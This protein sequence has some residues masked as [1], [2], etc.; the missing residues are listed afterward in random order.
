MSDVRNFVAR[1]A[2]AKKS[3]QEIKELTAA[4]YGDQAIHRT[5]IYSIIKKVK[6]GGDATD[7]RGKHSVRRQEGGE[8]WACHH[9][10]TC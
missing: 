2:L 9:Q 10:E 4:A 5:Q 7:Q 1:L 8:R 6:E 3:F